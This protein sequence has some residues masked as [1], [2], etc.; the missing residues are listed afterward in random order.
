MDEEAGGQKCRGDGAGSR[1]HR[2][3]ETGC[4]GNPGSFHYLVWQRCQMFAKHVAPKISVVVAP[5]GVDVVAVVLRVLIRRNGVGR[6]GALLGGQAGRATCPPP[7]PSG[8]RT[9]PG[10]RFSHAEQTSHDEHH[11]ETDDEA[12]GK[13]AHGN[14]F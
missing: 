5:H 7:W 11:G 12:T 9:L 1:Q 13:S 4:L 2:D 3:P 8:A 10:E 14:L 6:L